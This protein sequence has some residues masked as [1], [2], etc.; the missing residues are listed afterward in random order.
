MPPYTK[1]PRPEGHIQVP[2]SP[3]SPA[4]WGIVAAQFH[5][6]VYRDV[7]VALQAL[8]QATTT[9]QAQRLEKGTASLF[10]EYLY[11]RGQSEFTNRLVPTRLRGPK[12]LPAPRGR[13][14]VDAGPPGQDPREHYGDWYEEVR[15]SRDIDDSVKELTDSLLRERDARES[16][17]IARAI[18]IPEVA[19][20]DQ[21][22]RRATVRHYCGS[23]SALMDASTNAEVAA[24]FATGGGAQP[25]AKGQI[26]MLWAI[27]LNFL[28]EL[29]SYQIVPVVNGLRIV[30][31]EERELWGDNKKMFEDQG[32]MPVK[33]E[34]TF[35]YLPFLRP[36]NQY[37]RFFSLTGE[38]Q[39]A[40]PLRTELTWWSILERRA[41]GCAFLQDGKVYE[42]SSR[43]ITLDALLPNNEPLAKTLS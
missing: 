30:A 26:G 31:H 8:L 7:R 41:I 28:A 9:I 23:P 42:N 32:I 40:L 1:L 21:F 43:N 37:A 33:P 29:F 39:Q 13:Y 11:F 25:P 12:G 20:L 38:N 24:F 19:A 34:L 5:Y 14:R 36:I 16:A 18:R 15:P 17:D 2:Y 27:D 3:M 6:F 10:G 22:G 4:N 35:S